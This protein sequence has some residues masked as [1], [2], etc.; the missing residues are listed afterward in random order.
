MDQ[1]DFRAAF[2]RTIDNQ[3]NPYHPLMWILGT[4][5]IGPGTRIGGFSEINAKGA[6]VVI[7]KGCDIASFVAINV[8]DSHKKAI[9]LADEIDRRD[10]IIGDHVF[11][12]SHSAILGGATIGHHSVIAAGTI[13]R[14]GDI[15]PYSLV[16]G[17]PAVVKPGYYLR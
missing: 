14:A 5:E 9:G 4:P 8:A 2:L 13:V 10:I 7:G 17:N 16:V 1:K 11:I 15:P 3:E 6:R 12:G